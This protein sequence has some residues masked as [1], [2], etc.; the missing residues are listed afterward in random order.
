MNFEFLRKNQLVSYKPTTKIPISNPIKLSQKDIQL[1]DLFKEIIKENDIKNI[2]L[3]AVGGWVRDHLINNE[4]NDLD[5]VIKGFDAKTL[6]KMLNEKVHNKKLVMVKNKIKKTDGR[7]LYLVKT[8]IYDIMIDFVELKGTLL[9][10]AKRRDFTFNAIYYN[11]L[12]NKIEDILGI[13]I[14]DLE[15]GF[16]RTCVDPETL[17]NIDSLNI[18]RLLRFAT[19][20]Q[21]VIDDKALNAIE[22]NKKEYQNNLL[23]TISKERLHKEMISIFSGPNPS[24][25][26]YSFYELGMLE[27]ILH[28]DLHKNNIQWFCDKDIIN[29]VNIFIVGKI[30]MDKYKQ[31]FEEN[32]EVF[33]SKYQSPFYSILLIIYMRNFTDSHN[34]MIARIMLSEVIKIESK[35]FLKILNHFDEFNTFISNNKFTRLNVGI[36]LGRILVCNISKLILISVSNEYVNKINSN[37][38]LNDIDNNVLDEIFNKYYEFFKFI[39]KENLENVNQIK[40]IIDGKEI[41]KLFPGLSARYLGLMGEILV[42]KQIENN[43]IITKDIAIKTIQEK[44]EELK[45][46]LN[47]ENN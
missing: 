39:K 9:E 41:Q 27:Y 31:Y 22:K 32:G 34:N 7:E 30:C 23:K 2:E 25:A 13:G 42:N 5:I 6:V 10:D 4:S 37:N 12:E 19:K 28:L 47:E 45:I 33:D 36:L 14:T 16:V 24:F 35:S 40:P 20:Y 44:I 3:R 46:D 38:I 21:F 8:T 11:I 43:N 17:F 15:N 29:C 26:I 18:L 1:F